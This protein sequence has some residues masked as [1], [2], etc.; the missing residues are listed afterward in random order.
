VS[1][2]RSLGCAGCGDCCEEIYLSVSVESLQRWTTAA[3]GNV[4]DPATDEGWAWWKTEPRPERSDRVWHDDLRPDAIAQYAV[5]GDRRLNADF[6]TE[7]WHRID[8]LDNYSC[9]A[10]DPVHRRCTAYEERPPVCAGYPW[11]DR[12]P[13]AGTITKTGS[14]CSYLLDL[15]PAQRPEGARPLIPIEVLR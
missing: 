3:L 5:D 12:G 1:E 2:I 13:N 15:P 11:Y 14:R 8:G 7:H 9:D 6:L 4:P 10:F